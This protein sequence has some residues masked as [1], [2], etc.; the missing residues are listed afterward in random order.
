[1]LFGPTRYECPNCTATVTLVRMATKPVLHTCAG[2]H[3]ILA[4]LVPAGTACKIEANDRDDYVAGELVQTD[5]RGRPI[6]S[7]TTTRDD[8]QD[9]VVYA[10]TAKA[11]T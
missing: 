5:D 2:L 10:P 8:G 6:M 4:P 3:G 7:V 9:T 1:M 11:G